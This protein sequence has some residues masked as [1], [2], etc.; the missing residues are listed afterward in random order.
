V[1]M[2]SCL[3]GVVLIAVFLV[4]GYFWRRFDCC[5]IDPYAGDESLYSLETES[6]TKE[7]GNWR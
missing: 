2:G 3:N 6:S 7:K 5:G 1:A 4:V